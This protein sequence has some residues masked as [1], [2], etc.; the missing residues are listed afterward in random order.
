MSYKTSDKNQFLDIINIKILEKQF[1]SSMQKEHHSNE[2][3]F[4]L[5]GAGNEETLRANTDDFRNFKIVPS[6]MHGLFDG[7]A[8]SSTNFLGQTLASPIIVSP[9]AAHG[10]VHQNAE[11]ET[12]R[13]V[14]QSGSVMT[15]SHF[16][17]QLVSA[18]HGFSPETPWFYHYDEDSDSGLNKYL[19]DAAVDNKAE[20]IVIGVFGASFGRRER[21][22]SNKF[23]FPTELPFQQLSAYPNYP[24]GLDILSVNNRKHSD[25]HTDR[26]KVIKQYTKLPVIIKGIQSGT[27]AIR[28][29]EAGADT[30]WVSNTGGRQLDGT[31]STIEALPEISDAVNKRVPIIF[32]SG[33]RN[34]QHVFKA[35]ALGA[36]LVSLGRPILYGLHLGGSKGVESVIRH[37][38]SELENTML[39]SGVKSLDE[40]HQYARVER[41]S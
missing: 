15:I 40:L 37:F 32:D 27:D 7:L 1:K 18:I 25:I 35:L 36:D 5:G 4:I 24:K 38:Q 34:G 17:N 39:L 23:D 9:S 3:D 29:I 19:L 41:H 33:I 28:A 12:I 10:L 14:S 22:L 2:A 13:G 8:D 6:V 31:R 16:S 30:I 26:I 20:A 11:L 21:D